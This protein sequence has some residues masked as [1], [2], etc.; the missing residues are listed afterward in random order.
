MRKAVF[1]IL[2]A[3]MVLVPAVGVS[4]STQDSS[5][6]SSVYTA[7]GE[8]SEDESYK[9]GKG[10]VIQIEVRNQ[11]EFSGE[12][13][14]GPD[15]DIQYK[16]VGD[17]RAEGL[18]KVELQEKLA[19]DLEKYVKFPEVSVTI[20]QYRSKFVYILGAVGRPG[21]YPMMGNSVTLRDALMHAGLPTDSAALR[22]VHVI[23]PKEST[24][25]FQKVDIYRLL[26]EGKLDHNLSLKP[27]DLVVVPSTIPSE[28]N[29]A[30][31]R[32]LAPFS[33]A[34]IIEDLIDE[35]N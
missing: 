15:G 29:K 20:S 25:E 22:R 5:D 8:Q 31:M 7:I 12:Y 4:Q 24:P 26:Y 33:R 18:T 35:Y 30:L 27:G 9:L 10:D 16:F 13:V 23:T 32:L 14:V 2:A 21:K 28:I 19:K 17:L 11:P 1:L 34:A 6:D 3:A